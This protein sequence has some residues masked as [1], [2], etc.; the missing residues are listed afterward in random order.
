MAV[1]IRPMVAT[2]AQRVGRMHH[3]A[4]IDT[5]GGFLPAGYLET[6]WTVRDAVTFW[7]DLLARPAEPE[8]S[9][10]VAVLGGR[11][12][13]F[14]VAGRAREL[15]GRPAPV[16][17]VE[18]RAL[19]VAARHLGSGLG[20]RL[21]DEGLSAEQAAELWVFARNARARAFYDRNGFRADGAEFT[22]H[23]FPDLPEVRLVR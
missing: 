17:P 7:E 9:R 19:Y 13:G 1:Q 16:R 11:V 5:Y 18:L 10:L 3:H 4:W 6:T 15:D 8:L 22:D 23:R 2:D 14:V 21:L 20:Q 12:V